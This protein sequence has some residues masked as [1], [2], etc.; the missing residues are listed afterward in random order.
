M[1]RLDSQS[2]TKGHLS[3]SNQHATKHQSTRSNQ[4]RLV[5]PYL[6]EYTSS[7]LRNSSKD[8]SQYT[9]EQN[10]SAQGFLSSSQPSHFQKK[11]YLSSSRM[12]VSAGGA[13]TGTHTN[14]KANTTTASLH[15]FPARNRS[16]LGSEG[17]GTSSFVYSNIA[18]VSR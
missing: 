8:S 15:K 16:P 4:K 13:S 10:P 6:D 18:S 1:M 7:R 17:N 3:T 14:Q 5:K 9:E 11:T 12:Y 2:Q